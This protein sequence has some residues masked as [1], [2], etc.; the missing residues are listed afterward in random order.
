MTAYEAVEGMVGLPNLKGTAEVAESRWLVAEPFCNRTL[1]TWTDA[2]T[3]E[4]LLRVIKQV[5]SR[6]QVATT[7][8]EL[9]TAPRCMVL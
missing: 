7:E 3:P 2:D 5:M 8:A 9:N 4:L 1:A 6:Q